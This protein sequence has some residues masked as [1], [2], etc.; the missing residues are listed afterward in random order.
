MIEGLI[1]DADAMTKEAVKDETR[2]MENYEGYVKEANKMTRK[3]H[4]A[5]L[6]RQLEV[7]KLEEFKVEEG[8]HLNETIKTKAHIRQTNIDLY[9]VERCDYLIKNYAVRYVERQEEIQ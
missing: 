1:K 8:I 5:I 4:A 6:N 3:R 9:G 7:G 2:S